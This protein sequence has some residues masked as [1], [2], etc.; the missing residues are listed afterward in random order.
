MV[1]SGLRSKAVKPFDVVR[2]LGEERDRGRRSPGRE[3]G[4]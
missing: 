4:S 2:E 3:T 1:V